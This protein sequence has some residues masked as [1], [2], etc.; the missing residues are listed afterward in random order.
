MSLCFCESI[1]LTPNPGKAL[2]T[3]VAFC[4][5]FYFSFNKI[6]HTW[7]SGRDLRKPEGRP[8]LA[9]AVLGAGRERELQV[10]GPFSRCY[11]YQ[12]MVTPPASFVLRESY[13]DGARG[14][15]G[16]HCMRQT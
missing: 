14:A 1:V 13:Q 7:R 5:C 4:F 6:T 12:S 9:A 2:V 8:G 11:K 10:L 15:S 3:A 16:L